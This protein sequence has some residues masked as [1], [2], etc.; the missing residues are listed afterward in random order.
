M[1]KG[2]STALGIQQALTDDSCFIISV[3][4]ICKSQGPKR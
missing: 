2:R 3:P 1:S 4:H